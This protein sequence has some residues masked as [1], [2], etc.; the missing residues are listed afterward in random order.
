MARRRGQDNMRY[1][2]R[3]IRRSGTRSKMPH[4]A[5]C[6][7]RFALVG[8]CGIQ[9]SDAAGTARRQGQPDGFTRPLDARWLR[10]S[11]R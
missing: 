4:G 6:R 1:R 10:Q 8:S 11:E 7:L 5:P 2:R 9:T 3:Q